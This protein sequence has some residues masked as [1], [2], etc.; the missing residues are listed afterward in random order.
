M[1]VLYWYFFWHHSTL[2]AELKAAGSHAHSQ[3][4]VRIIIGI[5]LYL[6]VDTTE[7]NKQKQQTLSFNSLENQMLYFRWYHTIS[8]RIAFHSFS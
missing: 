8:F 6:I 3:A 5:I 7:H 4:L 2:A 1:K